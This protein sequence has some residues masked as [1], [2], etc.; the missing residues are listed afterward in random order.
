MPEEPREPIAATVES[1]AWME[2]RWRGDHG[3]DTLEEHWSSPAADS[4]IGMFR[5]IT[6]GKIKFYELLAI[7]SDGDQLTMRI[8]HFH[9][10]LKGWEE[11]DDAFTLDLTALNGAKAVWFARGGKSPV[12]LIYE[13]DGSRMTASFEKADGVA[14][15]VGPFAYSLLP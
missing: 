2:G 14:G 7:E 15:D 10:G 9:P 3:G 11:K 1:L 13:R 12:W 6:D 5:W 8:K 4:V